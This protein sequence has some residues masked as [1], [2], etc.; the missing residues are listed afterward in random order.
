MDPGGAR[1]LGQVSSV[2]LMSLT[3]SG[4]TGSLSLGLIVGGEKGVR[5]SE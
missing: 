5:K 2:Q 1:A 3:W 4:I